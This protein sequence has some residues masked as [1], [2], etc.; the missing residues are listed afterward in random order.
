MQRG[1]GTL[2]LL[3]MGHNRPKRGWCEKRQEAQ[4]G[5][6]VRSGVSV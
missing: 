2:K 5:K 1:R 4:H 3:Y 6:P